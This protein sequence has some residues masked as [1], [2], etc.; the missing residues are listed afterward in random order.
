MFD[1]TTTS[2]AI[3]IACVTLVA[4]SSIAH[5]SSLTRQGRTAKHKYEA[6]VDRY[7]D[8]DGEA[9]E[10][11]VED[12][13]DR[14]QRFVLVLGSAAAVAVA[15]ASAVLIT[16][17]SETAGAYQL[18]VQQWLQFASWVRFCSSMREV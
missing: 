1:A 12:F 18:I 17:R 5:V 13:S 9:T 3:S 11:S 8:E 7:E 4:L 16:T 2:F 6:L 15:A 14:I 10:Q